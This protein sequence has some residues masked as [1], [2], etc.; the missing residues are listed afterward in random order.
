MK[1]IFGRYLLVGIANTL[2][3]SSLLWVFLSCN[4]FPYPLSVA[5]AFILAMVFQYLANKYFTFRTISHSL[6]EVFRYILSA[7]LNYTISVLVIWVS[8]DLIKIPPLLASI[9]SATT[10]AFLGFIVSFFWVYRK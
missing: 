5:F 8:L 3:Y 4:R 1:S 7:I 2:I 6:G 10:A 9:F